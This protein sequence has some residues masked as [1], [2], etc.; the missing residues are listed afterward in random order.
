LLLLSQLLLLL[1]SSPLGISILRWLILF[2]LAH[3]SR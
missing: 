1:S 3:Q 2:N